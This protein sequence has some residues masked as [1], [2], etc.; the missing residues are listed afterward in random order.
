[1]RSIWL[2]VAWIVAVAGGGVGLAAGCGSSSA[3]APVAADAGDASAEG[4][5]VEAAADAAPDNNQDPTVYP[6]N[7]HPIPQLD[8]DKWLFQERDIHPVQANTREDGR[9]LLAEAAAANVLAHTVTYKLED[10]NHALQDMKQDR[11][12]GTGVLIVSAL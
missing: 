2:V 10:A 12:S 11:I 9:E 7:H 1:M 3:K 4:A 8:Y 5:V 6:S